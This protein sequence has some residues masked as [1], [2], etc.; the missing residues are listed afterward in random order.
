MKT[1][2]Q[3][4]TE[5]RNQ[6]WP[7]GEQEN[8]VSAHDQL[9]QE[10]AADIAKWVECEQQDNVNLIEFCNT[11]FKCGMTVIPAPPGVV[12]RIFTVANKEYCDPVFYRQ[13]N[14]PGPECWAR[15]LITFTSPLNVGFPRLPMGF[16][17]A[18]SSTDCVCGRA[19]TGI[20]AFYQGNIYIA[21]WIQSN[22]LIVIE[23]KGIKTEWS[24]GD[25]VNEAQDY[26]KALKLYLQYAHERDYGDL[27]RA[28]AF[29]NRR[30]GSMDEGLYADAL[31]DLMWQ[32]REQTKL[33]D[34]KECPEERVRLT[35]ELLDDAVPE[36]EATPIIAQIAN[37]GDANELGNKDVADLVKGWAPSFII[38]AGNNSAHPDYDT[39][40]GKL[41]SDYI[42]PYSGAYGS[43]SAE[44]NRFYP[45]PGKDDWRMG[46]LDRFL[47]FLVLPGNERYYS[48][49]R[50]VIEF[51]IVSSDPR[52][53]AG[54]TVNSPQAQ[55]LQ[56]A[57]AASTAPWKVV[58]LHHAPYSSGLDHG[59]NPDLQWPFHTWGATAVLSGH[60]HDY[61]RLSVN[62]I[63]YFVIG[64][65]GASL[66]TF[67]A[68]LAESVVRYNALFGAMR[69]KAETAYITFEMI[70]TAS[71]VVDTLTLGTIP[72]TPNPEIY[73]AIADWAGDTTDTAAVAALVAGW[74]AG[75]LVTAG[76]NYYP[77]TPE[78]DIDLQIGKPYHTFI[79]PYLGAYGAGAGTNKFF[80]A[81][82]NHDWD[83]YR[84]TLDT[85]VE[86]L[87]PFMDFFTLP[88][89][90]ERY[91]DVCLGDVH[92]FFLDS[93][94]R[95]PDGITGN[96]TQAQWLRAKL[97]LS[98]SP[99]KV[100]VLNDSP[101]SSTTPTTALIWTFGFWGADMVI[102]A[103]ALNYERFDI[104]GVPFINNGLGG[105]GERVAISSPAAG[106][107]AQYSA[108]Y[109]AGRLTV[110]EDSLK[111]EFV[112]VDGA[113]IDTIEL[114]Q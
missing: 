50:G 84:T 69:I 27:Q 37:F 9:F 97:A 29:L 26:K 56:A 74:N 60:D 52:E 92:L 106:S 48:V 113:V 68:P 102:S 78:K 18:E 80:P 95:E 82:G 34:S 107:E 30:P 5:I 103:G 10:A 109:G 105:N 42:M 77:K 85:Q 75:T 40:V 15:N 83:M 6:T 79:E 59:S 4:K 81:L 55:W 110:T 35:S 44:K 25:L 88:D 64:I 61:E 45:A 7:S 36:E 90:N 32:C 99:W 43:G 87:Q 33:R 39:T 8:L 24:D 16:L 3:L 12:T 101:Y 89:S 70:N 13:T 62:G 22:E 49:V 114:T 28:K 17:Q 23:W 2:G 100:V 54:V 14:W 63:P 51:F 41:F 96:S 86:S 20:W 53:P 31:A 21:P 94:T 1:W 65:G 47:D 46:A 11:H 38:T 76:D 67:A 19:R 66:R 58:L 98:T 108:E 57:L 104:Q 91:Y 71:V 111:Y 72:G 73:A 112:N 93:Y